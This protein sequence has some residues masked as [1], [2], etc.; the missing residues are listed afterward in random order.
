VCA[1]HPLVLPTGATGEDYAPGEF[2]GLAI[3]VETTG[4][5][6]GSDKV[7][8]LAIRTFRYNREGI[9]THIYEPHC[10]RED[11]DEP[12]SP[13]I[14]QITGL[15]NEDVK[16]C[17]ID[18]VKATELM[19]KVGFVV[20]HNSAF[21]RKFVEARLPEVAGLAWC[22]SLSQVDWR[23]RGMG[24]TSLGFL[25]HECGYYHTGHRADSDVDALIQV[26]RHQDANGTTA[27][28]EL[29]ERGSA[30]GWTVK[31]VGAAFESKDQLKERGYRW[32][33]TERCWEIEIDNEDAITSEQVWLHENIY[34]KK[35]RASAGNPVIEIV[36]ARTRFR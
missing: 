15:T 31:A 34:T 30:L 27:L 20:A 5:I 17:R 33:A 4:L 29:I 22:C 8:E 12:I 9:I 2:G 26:L 35:F 11:P 28:T 18:D 24:H 32:N 1:L 6:V 25:L 3:D 14:T 13:A 16:G 10:W 36:D 7:I 21:D 19:K 23:A